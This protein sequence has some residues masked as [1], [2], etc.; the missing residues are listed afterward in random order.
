MSES[1]E[2]VEEAERKLRGMVE[3]WDVFVIDRKFSGD[4][5]DI[6]LLEALRDLGVQG[7]RIVWT[8]FAEEEAQKDRFTPNIVQC[9][10]LGAWDYLNKKGARY[11]NTFTDVIVSA[12]EGLADRLI[13]T[14]RAEADVQPSRFVTEHF[15]EIY[16]EYKAQF[17]AFARDPA[18][19]WKPLAAHP[20][21]YGLQRLSS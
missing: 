19:G 10:R 12:L 18:E 7:I 8:A 2:T 16:N 9:M 5:K 1:C 4:I 20:S 13:A 15:K 11:G 6:H 17:V 14:H 21:L 3:Q